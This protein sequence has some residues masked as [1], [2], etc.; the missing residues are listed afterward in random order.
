[1]LQSITFLGPFCP[2]LAPGAAR[3]RGSGTGLTNSMP[4]RCRLDLLALTVLRCRHHVSRTQSHRKT[5]VSSQVLVSLLAARIKHVEHRGLSPRPV[6]L[7]EMVIY[8]HAFIQVPGVYNNLFLAVAQMILDLYDELSSLIFVVGQSTV[9]FYLTL[10]LGPGQ[11]RLDSGSLP[12]GWFPLPDAVRGL[13]G[14]HPS[15]PEYSSSLTPEQHWVS[16]DCCAS[17]TR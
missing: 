10:S 11:P 16:K 2:G 7:R 13:L 8:V 6:T 1:M 14:C 17:D 15:A 4:R 3:W 5:G 12:A 9:V